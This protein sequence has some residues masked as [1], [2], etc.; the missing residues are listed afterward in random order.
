[1]NPNKSSGR[2]ENLPLESLHA[3]DRLLVLLKMRGQ[4]T[5]AELAE[6]LGITAE[7]VRQ[8]LLRLAAEGLVEAASESRGV[9][10]PAHVW[11]LTATANSRFPDT[12]AELTAQLIETI[13]KTLG[14]AA[15]DRVIAAREKE[16][17]RS[18]SAALA[19][20]KNM[21]ERIAR[22]ASLRST[23]GYMAEWQAEGDG[24]RLI[25]NHCPICTATA[26]CLNLCRA[27]LN[28]FRKVLGSEVSV[29][30]EEHIFG[31]ARRCTYRI[32]RRAP[33]KSEY[34]HPEKRVA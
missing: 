28:L 29:K 34:A 2:L 14:D 5:A 13:R 21:E 15:L 17:C 6:T 32:E 26:A 7:A 18:Y 22:L 19:G 16:L 30:R 27:E 31:G 10:R 24:F 8:Q 9:G 25:E 20:T 11:K 12:H 1:V 23:E 33:E 3:H 4:S